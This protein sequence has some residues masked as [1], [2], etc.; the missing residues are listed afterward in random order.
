MIEARE[1]T[2][3]TEKSASEVVRASAQGVRETT[4][5]TD[6]YSTY[7]STARVTALLGGVSRQAIS[8]RVERHTLLRV[9]TSDGQQ[10]FPEFQFTDGHVPAS[11]KR[12][13]QILLPAAPDPWVV[14]EW[15]TIPLSEFDDRTA[16]D[17]IRDGDWREL[18]YLNALA[19]DVASGWRDR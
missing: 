8:G 7:L 18:K 4:R 5:G 9:T 10:V 1:I 13:L 14:V 19:Q 2:V 11:M 16:V 6:P 15:L 3:F 17:V 12:I